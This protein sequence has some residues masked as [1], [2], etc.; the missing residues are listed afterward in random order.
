MGVDDDLLDD[1]LAWLAGSL[2]QLVRSPGH[3]VMS[4]RHNCIVIDDG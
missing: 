1:V 4:P 3:D 2:V